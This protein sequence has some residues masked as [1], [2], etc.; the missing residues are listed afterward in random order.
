MVMRE[1]MENLGDEIRLNREGV[2]VRY[3][4]RMSRFGRAEREMARPIVE[5]AKSGVVVWE[6]FDKDY[7]PSMNR[8]ESNA[9]AKRLGASVAKVLDMGA[10]GA[11]VAIRYLVDMRRRQLIEKFLNEVVDKLGY[12]KALIDRFGEMDGVEVK[13][14]VRRCAEYMMAVEVSRKYK[15]VLMDEERGW[16]GRAGL[17]RKIRR[18]RRR[19]RRGN[20]RDLRKIRRELKKIEKSDK[21]LKKLQAK[22][23]EM[24]RAAGARKKLL[25][26]QEMIKTAVKNAEEALDDGID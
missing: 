6:I 9:T 24:A 18:D 26:E 12:Q 11:D 8:I 3:G 17:A 5:G 20:R 14:F 22:K 21:V 1:E 13:D 2:R 15:I 10:V 19:V 25:K 23:Q 16:W 4:E 7:W